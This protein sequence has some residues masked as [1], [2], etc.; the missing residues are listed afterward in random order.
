MLI[1][2]N[3]YRV[4]AVGFDFVG[5]PLLAVALPQRYYIDVVLLG[6]LPCRFT[7]SSD[8]RGCRV[9]HVLVHSS[10]VQLLLQILPMLLT[11]NSCTQLLAVILSMVLM[12]ALFDMRLVGVVNGASCPVSG[13]A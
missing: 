1:Q 12:F 6:V 4:V 2:L 8:R 11:F 9:F 10:V 13:G 7:P 3:L 5:H